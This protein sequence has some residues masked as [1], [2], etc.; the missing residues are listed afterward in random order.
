MDELVYLFELDSVRNS[1]QEIQCGQ[2]ALF[3]EVVLKGNRVVLSFNQLTDSEGFLCALRDRNIYTQIVSLFSMGV[4]KYSRFAPGNYSR[5]VD[6]ELLDVELKGCRRQYGALFQNGVL[7]EYGILPQY[8]PQSIV[9]TSS[10]YVQNAVERC[11]NATGE[12]F[13]FSALPFSTEDQSALSAIRYALQYSDPSILEELDREGREKQAEFAR[14]Y[15]ELILRLSREPLANNPPVLEYHPPM[16][17]YLKWVLK[18]C[19]D[20]RDTEI[21]PLWTVLCQG[22]E[23]IEQLWTT[24]QDKGQVNDRS[25]WYDTLQAAESSGSDRTVLCM[26]EAIVD[27]CYNYTIAASISGLAENWGQEEHFWADFLDRLPLYWEDGQTGV[28]QFLKPDSTQPIVPP[29]SKKLP[30]WDVAVRLMEYAPGR[31][32]RKERRVGRRRWKSC[33]IS[34]LFFQVRS[35]AA[36]IGLFVLVSFLLEKVENLFLHFGQ[37]AQISSY[38]LPLLSIVVFGIAGSQVSARLNLL[39]IWD[40]FRQFGSALRDGGVLL[41]FWRKDRLK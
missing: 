7:K 30:K 40:S 24:V 17:T 15:V 23:C 36:Y 11:L 29:P 18:R 3:R 6:R 8:S 22:A 10:H 41:N 34:S 13:L 35:A 27:L 39:D 19:K 31:G 12:K 9:R 33:V 28:H 2:Q 14:A 16:E 4:L 38:L 37:Q 26:A 1:P 32:R 20:E 5:P 21:I 25:D